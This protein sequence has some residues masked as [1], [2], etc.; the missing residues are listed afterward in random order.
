MARGIIIVLDSLGIG[1]APDANVFG[2]KN[3]NTL[4]NIIN[5]RKKENKQNSFL[6]IPNLTQLGLLDAL[7]LSKEKKSSIT[8]D[9]KATFGV[10]R[11]FSKSKDTLTGHW[12]IA[13]V[14]LEKNWLYFPKK[15]PAI[16]LK[17]INKVMSKF[18]IC[19]ILGNCHASGTE[20][21][22]SLGEEHLRTKKPILYT[23]SDSV[24]Q[25]AVHEE[26]ISINI[27]Y[28]ICEELSKY[29][30]PLGV[31]RI[32]SR[33]FLGNPNQGFIRTKNR[34]DF[35]QYPPRDTLCDNIFKNGQITYGIGKI[36]EIFNNRSINTFI[37]NES[38]YKLFFGLL[39]CMDKFK[40]GD[41]I[42]ANFVEFDTL[43]GHRRDAKGYAN[44]LEKFD[45]LLPL[46]LKKIKRDD[47][48]IITADHG[49]DPTAKGSDHTREQVP[50]LI[51]KKGII[52]KSLGI[53]SFS[54]IA[55]TMAKHLNIKSS[56]FG[57]SF[58]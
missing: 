11:S 9:S 57:K 2:D 34:K 55:A 48:L 16:P 23:S 54:D 3:A 28:D 47:L 19:G 43:Y 44:A 7:R 45:K 8:L 12:E 33:P 22:N 25:V 21:I 56:N 14:T 40:S 31:S 6:D 26:I 39:D 53:V 49:N 30:F 52:S 17:K 10:G 24:I 42:F 15:V 29:F 18:S 4:Q 46:L 51:Y 32:I 38:D 50:I 58:L 36:G 13:G 35:S 41:M 27:L 37:K 20:I 5:F 1:G